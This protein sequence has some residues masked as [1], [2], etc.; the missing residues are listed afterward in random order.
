M[1][2]N[3]KDSREDKRASAEQT[4]LRDSEE[5]STDVESCLRGHERLA[6]CSDSPTNDKDRKPL[7]RIVLLENYHSGNLKEDVSKLWVET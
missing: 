6:G 5:E 2:L 1:S 3:I 7:G 4:R